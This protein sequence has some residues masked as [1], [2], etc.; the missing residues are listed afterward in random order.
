MDAGE[1]MEDAGKGE[2]DAGKGKED[3]GEG[4]ERAEEGKTK[5]K[6]TM[7]P[8][9]KKMEIIKFWNAQPVGKRDSNTRAAYPESV[10]CDGQ[11]GRWIGASK[12][13]GWAHM[14]QGVARKSAETRN[15]FRFSDNQ[16]AP[17]K[18]KQ[19]HLPVEVLIDCDKV[20]LSRVRACTTFAELNEDLKRK[21]IWKLLK[22][23]TD[24][25]NQRVERVNEERKKANE[26]LQELWNK[27]SI[28]PEE[29]KEA[30]LKPMAAVRRFGGEEDEI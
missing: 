15:W 30:Y 5:G 22:E 21:S 2:E 8:I 25:Y 17:L 26:E 18:G 20:L 13:Y 29:A 7:M 1:G 28:S 19:S 27:G 4:K 12:K 16:Q 6:K 14:P 23:S 11:V 9:A 10:K 24:R 3:A